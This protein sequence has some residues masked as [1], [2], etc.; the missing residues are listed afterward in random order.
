[1]L[2]QPYSL[3]RFLL[4]LTIAKRNQLVLGWSGICRRLRGFGPW[5]G[6]GSAPVCPLGGVEGFGL[7]GHP[8]QRLFHSAGSSLGWVCGLPLGHVVLGSLHSGG[9][10]GAL[11]DLVWA[12]LAFGTGLRYFEIAFSIVLLSISNV[13]F[14]HCQ[15]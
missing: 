12:S 14:P 13:V 10:L 5:L 4:F 9:L 15:C 6:W 11:I 3:H 7:L 8:S 1:M 2:G